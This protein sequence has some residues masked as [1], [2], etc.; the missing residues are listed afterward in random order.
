ML[1]YD[2][3]VLRP[4]VEAF[5]ERAL[6]FPLPVCTPANGSP[7]FACDG[8]FDD[9]YLA[10]D[11][12]SALE[13]VTTQPRLA[14]RLSQVPVGAVLAERGDQWLIRGATYVVRKTEYDGKGEAGLLFNVN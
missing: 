1:S 5:G 9:A 10:L 6:G 4:C 13:T 3:D 14:I 8:I 11:A 12:G 2:E 7:S